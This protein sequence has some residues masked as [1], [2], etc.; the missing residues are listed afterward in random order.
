V[1][2]CNHC[3]CGNAVSVTYSECVFLALVIQHAMRKSRIFFCGLS[4]CTKFFPHIINGAIF[5]KKKLLNIKFVFRFS[6]QH[7]SET[8]LILRVT[9]GDKIKNIHWSSC[10]VPVV[11]VRFYRIL[12]FLGI[13]SKKSSN[14]K[15]HENP[16][17]RSRV[18]PRG[19]AGGWSNRRT[20]MTKLIV[21]FRNFANATKIGTV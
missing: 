15:F 14:T 6:L 7:L 21:T 18:V 8:F 13:V 9:E 20:D 5:G 12:N 1:R 19:R 16:S 4:C 2:S 11:L 10:K 17:S 3:C